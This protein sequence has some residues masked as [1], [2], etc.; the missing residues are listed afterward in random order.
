MTTIQSD[1]SV[2]SVPLASIDRR[3]LSQA[4]YSALHLETHKYSVETALK[5]R[6]LVTPTGKRAQPVARKSVVGT[7]V[8]NVPSAFGARA[9]RTTVSLPGDRRALRTALAKRIERVFAG[10]CRPAHSASFTLGVVGGRVHIG[11]RRSG[12]HLQLI[13]VCSPRC[14]KVVAEALVQARYALASRGIALHAA[15]QADGSC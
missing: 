14:R 13:A 3:A 12:E 9:H 10:R 1:L 5:P 8:S 11:L 2:L 6:Q 7:K 15:L 4:W